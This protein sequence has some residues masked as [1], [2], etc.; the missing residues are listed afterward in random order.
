MGNTTSQQMKRQIKIIQLT[1][2]LFSDLFESIEKFDSCVEKEKDETI[3]N[4]LR[5]HK[6]E[7]VLLKCATKY[8][9]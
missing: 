2:D 8:I 6:K 3:K 1:D 9:Y 7:I 4:I 5:E